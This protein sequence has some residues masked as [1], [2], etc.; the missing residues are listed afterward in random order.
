MNPDLSRFTD[1]EISREHHWR[2]LRMLGDQRVGI[3][4]PAPLQR[5]EVPELRR[6]GKQ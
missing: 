6:R 1:N 3:T 2:M 4:V 5:R